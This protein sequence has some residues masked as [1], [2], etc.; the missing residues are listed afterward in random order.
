M[1][2]SPAFKRL[3]DRPG[4]AARAWR[5]PD[6]TREFEY[7]RTH[8]QLCAGSNLGHGKVHAPGQGPPRSREFID[9]LKLVDAAYPTHT[10]SA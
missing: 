2:R 6:F 7:K 8:G 4:L 1:T 5:A 3:H 9:F 10:R